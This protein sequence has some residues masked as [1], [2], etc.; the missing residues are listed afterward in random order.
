M[1]KAFDKPRKKVPTKTSKK[2]PKITLSTDAE[3]PEFKGKSWEE[4]VEAFREHTTSVQT[5]I[6]LLASISA[7]LESSYGGGETKRFAGEVGRSERRIR[8]YAQTY[9]VFHNRRRSELLEFTHHQIIAEYFE[10]GAIDNVEDIVSEAELGDW[11]VRD[12]EKYLEKKAKG[13]DKEPEEGEGVTQE[14]S[15]HERH[16]DFELDKANLKSWHDFLNSGG[17]MV[18]QRKDN[19]ELYY[20][21]IPEEKGNLLPKRTGVTHYACIPLAPE[22]MREKNDSVHVLG[23]EKFMELHFGSR[24]RLWGLLLAKAFV[25]INLAA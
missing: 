17:C 24:E 21:K 6:W 8:Q 5:H 4:H 22:Y 10:N 23:E 15:A 3:L 1:E 11:S 20:F 18:S 14:V 12:L 7:S 13:K 19:L 16:L 2:P 9:R 25:F